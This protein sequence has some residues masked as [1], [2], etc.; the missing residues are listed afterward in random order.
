MPTSRELDLV[1]LVET[2]PPPSGEDTA[3]VWRAKSVNTN[4]LNGT[5]LRWRHYQ[6]WLKH[7]AGYEL[8]PRYRY[9]W[10]VPSQRA[11]A[12]TED[13]QEN[14]TGKLVID[15]TRV[16]DGCRVFIKVIKDDGGSLAQQ[17]I[18]KY[19][20]SDALMDPR[21]HTAPLVDVFALPN[22]GQKALVMPLLRPWHSPGFDTVGEAIEF[23]RQ[24][25]EGM[26]FM[27]E[28]NIAHGDCTYHNIMYDA[29]PMYPDGFH[30]LDIDRTVAWDG[31]AKHFTRTERPVRYRF[32]DF[33]L[34]IKCDDKAAALR[35]PELSK[36][37]VIANTLYNPFPTD[38]WYLGNL[39]QVEFIEGYTGFGFMKKLVADMTKDDPAERPTMDEVV[40]RFE[41]ISSSLSSVTLRRPVT[42]CYWEFFNMPSDWHIPTIVQLIMAIPRAW[43]AA[44]K[45][46]CIL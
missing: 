5:E 44:W 41:N 24:I 11:H 26:Q 37:R 45:F 35:P 28:H 34:A 33:A 32:I 18:L 13:C 17:E 30:P 25:F 12:E 36:E 40:A 4:A 7:R 46:F 10:Q 8:R 1:R 3:E 14:M 20:S 19:L 39:I 2:T 6:P 15:A 38:V 31:K 43:R 42:R 23:V 9:D 27:H 21:N 29:T 16:S 22:S